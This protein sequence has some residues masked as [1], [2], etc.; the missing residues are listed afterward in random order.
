MRSVLHYPD[1]ITALRKGYAA[2]V[3]GLADGDRSFTLCTAN[4]LWVDK[5]YPVLPSFTDGVQYWYAAQVKPVDFR[6]QPEVVRELINTWVA[7][8]TSNRI[9]DLIPPGSIDSTTRLGITNAVYFKGTWIIKFDPSR[10]GSAEFHVS[11]TKTVPVQMME[12]AGEGAQYAYTETEDLQMLSMPYRHSSGKGLTMD[13]ILP[14]SNDLPAAEAALDPENLSALERSVSYHTVVVYFPKFTSR[15]DYS[16][17][18]TLTT[19]GIADAFNGR[20][21]FSRM[22][23]TR[24]LYIHDVIHS[25]WINVDEEG[26]EAAAATHVSSHVMASPKFVIF[27]AD[28]PF[29]YLIRD[30]DTGTILF[31]GRVVDP[32]AT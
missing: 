13:V 14:K 29:I 32:T 25:A 2:S 10:T 24:N 15:S 26:T 23:D 3:A 22:D 11:P 31:V 8:K 30:N 17:V 21:D 5:T 19:M 4:A 7:Q 27:R 20:A 6:G 18:P 16:L 9:P 12:Q 28:H 1:N